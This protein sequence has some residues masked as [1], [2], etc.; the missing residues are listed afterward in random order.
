[1]I[2]DSRGGPAMTS[3]KL[4]W[5]G[6]LFAMF[7]WFLEAFVHSA[8][9]G[10]GSYVVNLLPQSPNELWMRT[11]VCSLLIVFGIYAQSTV[12]KLKVSEEER[13]RVRGNALQAV[14][15]PQARFS[16]ASM[17]FL[18]LLGALT[19]WIFESFIHSSLFHEGEFLE[20]IFPREPNELWM[21][22]LV[23]C[24]LIALGIY[25]HSSITKLKNSEEERLRL[26]RELEES[27]T[28][29]LSGFVPICANCKDIREDNGTWIQI[30]G[31]IQ[32]HS[33][34]KFSHGICQKCA[35][36]LYPES[37]LSQ[38]KS[39]GNA[40]ESNICYPLVQG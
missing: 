22:L 37:D 39:L 20:N 5:L 2:A 19:F 27:L 40:L 7:F 15:I 16:G 31:Y 38:I 6:V 11:L 33:D 1:M 14:S 18:G 26:E 13:S 21:R 32:R 34:V 23:S 36:L 28:K 3:R 9:F 8:V 24:L 30:E 10:E 29:L 35:K 12:A 17:I 4:L 25:G